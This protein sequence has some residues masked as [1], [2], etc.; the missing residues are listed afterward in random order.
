MTWLVPAQYFGDP[1]TVSTLR[2]SRSRY[3]AVCDVQFQPFFQLDAKP[4]QV[5]QRVRNYKADYA[6]IVRISEVYENGL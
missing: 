6:N 5:L 3:L 2:Y 4:R 1:H